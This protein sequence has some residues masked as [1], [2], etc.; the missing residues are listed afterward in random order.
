MSDW[1]DQ[2]KSERDS[3]VKR[4]LRQ[5]Q[6]SAVNARCPGCTREHCCACGQETGRAGKHEDSL[7][8]E[9]ENDEI[10]PLC[11]DCY[12]EKTVEEV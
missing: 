6:H 9:L 12:R 10:G 4:A 5:D 3:G 11:V 8:I 2:I 7:Y 1:I